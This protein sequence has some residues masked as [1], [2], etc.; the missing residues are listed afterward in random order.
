MQSIIESKSLHS[1]DGLIPGTGEAQAAAGQHLWDIARVRS[2][3]FRYSVTQGSMVVEYRVPAGKV[4]AEPMP[5]PSWRKPGSMYTRLVA[6]APRPLRGGEL[7]RLGA[8]G[9]D[10]EHWDWPVDPRELFRM[11][12][13]IHADLIPLIDL[14]P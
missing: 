8:A 14:P 12:E 6:V 13:Q 7:K 9:L 1:V 5:P 3:G 10:V 4:L 11:V 2:E